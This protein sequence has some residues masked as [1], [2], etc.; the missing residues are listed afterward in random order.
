MLKNTLF[1]C[2]LALVISSAATATPV[3][4]TL[5]G[6][7]DDQGTAF[8]TF[9]YDADTNLFSNIS[10][11]TTPGTRRNGANYSRTDH[12]ISQRVVAR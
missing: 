3:Q 11:V 10:I 8:G 7:F 1:A 5:D 9:I 2:V 6:L 12:H 4:W